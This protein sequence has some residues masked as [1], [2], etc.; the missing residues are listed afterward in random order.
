MSYTLVSIGRE[1]EAIAFTLTAFGLHPFKGLRM[2]QMMD[3]TFAFSASGGIR[4]D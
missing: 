2:R 4:Y 1:I 3:S